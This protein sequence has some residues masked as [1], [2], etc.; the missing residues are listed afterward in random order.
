MNSTLQRQTAEALC[1][2]LIRH[3]SV[4]GVDIRENI[5]TQRQFLEEHRFEL[6]DET[7][8]LFRSTYR[9]AILSAKISRE[10]IREELIRNQQTL[11][12]LKAYKEA[13][14]Y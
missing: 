13:G 8:Q 4:P 3:L 11:T 6:D 12:V 10:Q 1:A 14:P 5:R 9:D 2:E 7:L